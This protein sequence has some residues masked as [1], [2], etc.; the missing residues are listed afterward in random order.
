MKK[1]LFILLSI[2]VI[3]GCLLYVAYDYATDYL[4]KKTLLMVAEDEELKAQIEEALHEIQV[5]P[6]PEN[7]EKTGVTQEGDPP[8]GTDESAPAANTQPSSVS[9]DDGKLSIDDLK[10]S[11]KDYVMSIY[12]RF[13]SSEINYVT[14]MLSNGLTV[15]EKREIKAIVYAK[16]SSE[17]VNTLYAIAKKYQ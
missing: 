10:P 9:T 2:F 15:E 8:K 1:W 3:I 13:T 11:D 6:L 17:E 7:A 16:V 14:S 12:K 4:V 5:A